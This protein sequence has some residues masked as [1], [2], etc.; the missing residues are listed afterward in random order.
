MAAKPLAADGVAPRAALEAGPLLTVGDAPAVELDGASAI[1]LGSEAAEASATW[2][3]ESEV[4]AVVDGETEKH[5]AKQAAEEAKQVA[6][7]AAQEAKEKEM[8]KQ[9]AMQAAQE[10]KQAAEEAKETAEKAAQEAKEKEMEKQLTKQVAKQAAE[11]AKQAAEA[12]RQAGDAAKQAAS[13]ATEAA[14]QAA[15]TASDAC[16][17]VSSGT[18]PAP[19]AP[20]TRVA[21]C[22]AGA[23][24]DMR[25]AL[26]VL[27]EMLVKPNNAT[28]F[29]VTD[30]EF[31]PMNND[32]RPAAER[33]ADA[34]NNLGYTEELLTELL[35]EAGFPR[36][37]TV[38]HLMAPSDYLLGQN[39]RMTKIRKYLAKAQKCA[40][41]IE[42]Q[43]AHPKNL[44]TAYKIKHAFDVVF[45]TR[46]DMDV[47]E[48]IRAWMDGGWLAVHYGN[49]TRLANAGALVIS[50]C[51]CMCINDRF[52]VSSLEVFMQLYANTRLPVALTAGGE[53]MTSIL[54]SLAGVSAQLAHLPVE[55]S[56]NRAL[57]ARSPSSC[58]CGAHGLPNCHFLHPH[59]DPETWV[60]APRSPPP[61]AQPVA[62]D[63]ALAAPQAENE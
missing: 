51:L 44:Q 24:R 8:E 25:H 54:L 41:L 15:K 31:V 52:A 4:L 35:E 10:A 9:A 18:L 32:N 45:R 56:R 40:D 53:E 3:N 38:L 17:R 49:I 42:A 22:V 16:D 2:A 6:E 23:A 60:P 28:V 39:N 62:A 33:E 26:S 57:A 7:E 21:V 1:N 29:F 12:A 59:L 58:N 37:Q 34:S 48:P 11:V 43:G 63:V 5:A 14:K 55:L 36:E 13:S 61:P 19:G 50:D 47:F 20:G 30:A 27:L 46:P